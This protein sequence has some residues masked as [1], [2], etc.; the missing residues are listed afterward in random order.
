MPKVSVNKKKC[1][2]CG[3]C[4]DVC[5]NFKLVKDKAQPINPNPKTIGCNKEAEESCPEGAITVKE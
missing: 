5:S 4:V 2:G 3:A 1:I